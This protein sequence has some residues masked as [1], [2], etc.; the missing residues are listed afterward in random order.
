MRFIDREL[1]SKVL[2]E[3]FLLLLLLWTQYMSKKCSNWNKKCSRTK[4]VPRRAKNVPNGRRNVRQQNLLQI[5]QKM[6]VNE[7]RVQSE[8]ITAS[9]FSCR[10]SRLSV[11]FWEL[12]GSCMAFLWSFIAL[13]GSYYG[14]V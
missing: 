12:A 9:Y 14:L 4:F 11:A 6:F 3:A 5:E 1:C 10:F 13:Y 2:K 8:N 7:N